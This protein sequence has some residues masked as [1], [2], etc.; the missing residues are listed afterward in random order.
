[1]TL[2]FQKFA[3]AFLVLQ[4]D[5][6]LGVARLLKI[7]LQ[8]GTSPIELTAQVLTAFSALPLAQRRNLT[9]LAATA[10]SQKE[11]PPNAD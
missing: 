7:P 6:Q 11:E 10:A 5:E 1:M 2:F 8:K 9:K 3:R 4:P